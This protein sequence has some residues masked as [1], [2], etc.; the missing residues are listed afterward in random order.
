MRERERGKDELRIN[1]N[2]FSKRFVHF[3]NPGSERNVMEGRLRRLKHVGEFEDG[4][5]G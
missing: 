2:D 1:T 4:S 5:N 3:P